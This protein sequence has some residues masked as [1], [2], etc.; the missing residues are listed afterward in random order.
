MSSKNE[1][2]RAIGALAGLAI[3]DALGTTLEFTARDS[4]PHVSDIVGGGPFNLKP[5]QWTDDTSMALCLAD[6]IL[7][8]DDVNPEDL[9]DRFV[10][11]RQKGYNSVNGRCFDIGITTSNALLEFMDSGNPLSGSEDPYSAGNGS[12]M[13]LSP[14][15][16]RW[17]HDKRKAQEAAMLQSRTTHGASQAVG[18]CGFFVHLL[19]EAITGVPKDDVLKNRE[20]VNDPAIAEIA[21][22]KWKTKSRDQIESTG[23]VVHTLEA[24]LWC[25]YNSKSFKEALITAVNLGGDA[26][27]TGA[28]TGQLAGALW[29]ISGIP[30]NWLEKLAWRN[31]IE[32]LGNKLYEAQLSSA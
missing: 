5:G 26:D 19:A 10:E 25:I 7:E 9:M 20:W 3:G 30:D 6:S 24:S 18:A 8:F 17:C 11:W 28:V 23:Y 15:A 13:R 16:I 2:D 27:T 31:K 4:K 1:R 22:G 21:S 32:H 29:G 14:I 12:L